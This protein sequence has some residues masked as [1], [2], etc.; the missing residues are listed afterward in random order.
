MTWQDEAACL[1][2][3][4]DYFFLEQGSSTSSDRA[5]AICAQCPVISDCL[6]YALDTNPQY[7]IWAGMSLR[8][9]RHYVAGKPL[10]MFS[11][12]RCR[13]EGCD[14]RHRARGYCDLHYQRWARDGDPETARPSGRQRL[15][16][17]DELAELDDMTSSEVAAMLGVS[18]STV[19]YNRRE[20]AA[21]GSLGSGPRSRRKESA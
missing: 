17:W 14:R 18:A 4:Q 3:N 2:M 8:E 13:V 1:G 7:G 15:I 11:E 6:D 19:R 10:P 12:P 21:A 16:D 9:R 20:L 5:K